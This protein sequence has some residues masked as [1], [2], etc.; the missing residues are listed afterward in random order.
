MN[1]IARKLTNAANRMQEST[2]HRRVIN[3]RGSFD[4]VVAA[5]VV[6]VSVVV[7]VV[8]IVVVVVVAFANVEFK[9]VDESPS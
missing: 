1:A 8:V 5:V 6:V 2:P 7:V 9:V 3:H 4:V